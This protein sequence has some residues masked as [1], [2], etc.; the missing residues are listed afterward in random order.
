MTK[1]AKYIAAA[2]YFLLFAFLFTIPLYIT[3]A[4]YLHIL[5]IV[6]INVI[7]AISLRTISS[8]G[9]LSMAHAGFY[10]I[11]A[12]T[13]AILVKKLGFS[14]WGTLWL[15]GLAAAIFALALGYLIVRVKRVY[16]SMLTLFIG[17]IVA[18]VLIQWRD[19]T[20]GNSGLLSI[21]SPNIINLF[22]R[23]IE[24][25]SKTSYYYLIL[26][27]VLIT[28]LVLYRIDSSRVGK[29]FLAVQQGDYV[30]ES[31]GINVTGYKVL[32]WTIGCFFAGIAGAFYAHYTRILTPNS[33]GV[34]PTIYI[35]VYM[36]VGG[37]RKFYGAIIGAII[38]TI[39]PE[40]FRSLQEYQ[41]FVF[42]AIL[43][44]II[45]L[46]PGGLVDLPAL[47]RSKFRKSRDVSVKHA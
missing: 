10:A 44:V 17:Q 21:P 9:Q 45:F 8:T 16:F 47:I 24:F 11:G 13:S 19:F 6:G 35:V 40:F 28:L 7:L 43:F 18:L 2:L 25:T 20:G 31:I 22:G 34:L 39:L 15:G 37:R 33:F 46:L 23:T 42:V 4:Y 12:Y 36:V 32:S 14:F 38:L 1:K 27:L 29:S 41:P 30:A 26:I 3:G 5:I